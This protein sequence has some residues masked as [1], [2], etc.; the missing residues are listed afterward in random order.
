MDLGDR[1]A[2][3]QFLV[4]DH[5]GQFTDS[6]DAVLAAAGIEALKIPLRSPRA[7]A[8]CGAVRAHRLG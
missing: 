2:D 4:R 5:A 1:A 3:F 6:F 7:N 8:F